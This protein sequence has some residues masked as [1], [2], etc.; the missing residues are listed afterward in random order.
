MS[1]RLEFQSNGRPLVH[2]PKP[3]RLAEYR[4]DY[5]HLTHPVGM[6]K[7]CQDK[8]EGRDYEPR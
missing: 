2:P 6:D 1:Q 5:N 7:Q 3:H 8:V 4:E